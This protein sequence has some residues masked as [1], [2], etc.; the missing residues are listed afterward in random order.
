MKSKYSGMS[1]MVTKKQP[2]VPKVP[3]LPKLSEKEEDEIAT[4]VQKARWKLMQHDAPF[5]GTLTMNLELKGVTAPW[6][7]SA[8]TDGETLYYNPA[9]FASFP[10]DK[11]REYVEFVLAHEVGHCI[12]RHTERGMGRDH[13]R[14]NVA[15]DIAVNTVLTDAESAGLVAPPQGCYDT[16]GKYRG[17][18]AEEIYRELG[19]DVTYVQWDVHLPGKGEGE[20][21]KDGKGGGDGEEGEDAPEYKGSGRKW[22][23]NAEKAAQAAKSQGKF[24][25]G[26]ERL[27]KLLR[28]KVNWKT[29]L[30]TF[31]DSYAKSDYNMRIP[32][33]RCAAR[34][35]WMPSLNIPEL[36]EIAVAIDSS[37]SVD[38]KQFSQF[39]SELQSIRD[40]YECTIHAF[41]CDAEIGTYRIIMPEDELKLKLVGGGGTD[42]RPVF[43]KI[44]KDCL[45]IKCLVYLTDCQGS[46]P[47]K[48]P[49]YP[50]LWIVTTDGTHPPWGTEV[51]LTDV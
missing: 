7:P 28:P 29:Q 37:G 15:I 38:E 19:K 46:F 24:P 34:G 16:A 9:W 27:M 20:Q 43:T 1:R 42:F 39:M 8:A 13:E 44:D 6:L 47:G 45:N 18:M 23:R 25:A 30:Q 36:G 12:F 49:N 31:V 48:Q 11:R 21:D 51:R 2:I 26:L 32:N 22:E 4:L 10:A 14:W 41:I 40:T 33:R 50:V 17:K 3:T 5:W 35:V